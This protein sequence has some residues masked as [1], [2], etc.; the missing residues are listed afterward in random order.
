MGA[1]QLIF[2]CLQDH[3]TQI[4]NP[5]LS[6][7]LFFFHFFFFNF[8]VCMYASPPASQ[9]PTA[10]L[11]SRSE[12]DEGNRPSST[13]T[14]PI[15]HVPTP[16]S[17]KAAAYGSG[18]HLLSPYLLK[19]KIRVSSSLFIVLLLESHVEVWKEKI[20]FFF[21][22]FLPHIIH[23]QGFKYQSVCILYQI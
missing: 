9:T 20:T 23:D 3:A 14:V 12:P 13:G 16:Q 5:H 15:H 18:A 7:F 8:F 22:F 10:I 17:P 11:W 19:K 21:I 2:I 1:K 4:P 6:F